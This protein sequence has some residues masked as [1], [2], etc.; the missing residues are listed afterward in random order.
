MLAVAK[1]V[2]GK[3]RLCSSSLVIQH[4]LTHTVVGVFPARSCTGLAI[5]RSFAYFA[6]PLFRLISGRRNFATRSV[7]E[8]KCGACVT[9]LTASPKKKAGSTSL[10]DIEDVT[11]NKSVEQAVSA[12]IR[13]ARCGSL[14]L[15]PHGPD[16]LSYYSVLVPPEAITSSSLFDI[17][18]GL[19]KQRFLA[20]QRLIH[21][22]LLLTL[23]T[24]ASG[25]KRQ[26]SSAAAECT[27]RRSEEWSA[28][29][30]K[31]W[32]TLRDPL[33]RAE[34]LARLSASELDAQRADEETLR[35]VLEAR[36]AIADSGS[37]KLLRAENEK[38][39]SHT[40]EGLGK[41]FRA[42]DRNDII[43]LI[44]RLRYWY[45]LKKAISDY[46]ETTG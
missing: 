27:T 45:S 15:S 26:T 12:H 4:S 38:R 30:N 3:Q 35:T 42:K 1:Q 2:L 46:V 13:C 17:D 5:Q 20:V 36:E 37:V 24:P 7:H 25:V 33:A 44:V 19:I 34:Y 14:R 32:E 21:P 11:L 31:G 39:V 10:L 40:I 8:S 29:C 41:A 28:W 18:V 23:H 22:D 6:C 9:R 43:R 16:A